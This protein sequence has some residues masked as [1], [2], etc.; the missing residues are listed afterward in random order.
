MKIVRTP[1]KDLLAGE[2]LTSWPQGD[3][4]RLCRAKVVNL[5]LNSPL[6][7]QEQ[8]GSIL[9]PV[10]IWVAKF[11]QL[12][13]DPP[14]DW[15]LCLTLHGEL[16]WDSTV[17]RYAQNLLIE[18]FEREPLFAES[19]KTHLGSELYKK[20][21]ATDT[22]DFSSL[23]RVAKQQVLM[24]LVPKL[25][26]QQAQHQGWRIRTQQN[27]RYGGEGRAPMVTWI[28]RFTRSTGV[29]ATPNAA[30]RD[31]LTSILCSTGQI[32]DDGELE[33]GG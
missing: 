8:E 9:F 7:A 26:A 28:V 23:P 6:H 20:I 12:H 31:A 17:C 2:G 5:D 32:R 21:N 25:I 4:V 13:V 24:A 22:V 10:V 15:S 18:N 19:C 27:L 33:E 3:H 16:P 14:L 30:Y 1:I 29:Y 11:A